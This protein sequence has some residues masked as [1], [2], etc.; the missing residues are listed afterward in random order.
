MVRGGGCGVGE[1]ERSGFE[2]RKL[3]W[4]PKVNHWSEAVF[5]KEDAAVEQ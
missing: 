3:L 1:L 4:P 2:S 5:S